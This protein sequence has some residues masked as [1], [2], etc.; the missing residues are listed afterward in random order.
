MTTREGNDTLTELTVRDGALPLRQTKLS[1]SYAPNTSALDILADISK[2][3]GLPVKPMPEKIMDKPY[4]RG[5][6]F[7]GK[8]EVAMKDVCQYLGLTWSIQKQRNSNLE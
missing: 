7:C 6:A 8:A 3:F 4:R 2:A 1:L 5:F